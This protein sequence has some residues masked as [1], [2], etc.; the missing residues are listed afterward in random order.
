M[1]IFRRKIRHPWAAIGVLVVVSAM[2]ARYGVVE[3]TCLLVATLGGVVLYKVIS[4][5]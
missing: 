4:G 3:G 1:T 2:L 5:E